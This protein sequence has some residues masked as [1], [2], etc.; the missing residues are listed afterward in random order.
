MGHNIVISDL[1]RCMFTDQLLIFLIN[2]V[3]SVSVTL[4]VSFDFL[5]TETET[6][7]HETTAITIIYYTMYGRIY[8]TCLRTPFVVDFYHRSFLNEG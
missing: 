7:A 4:L 8:Y 1:F 2:I 5:D 6:H 3:K